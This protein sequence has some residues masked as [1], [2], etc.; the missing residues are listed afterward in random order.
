MKNID[1]VSILRRF[2]AILLRRFELLLIPML[3]LAP[4]GYIAYKTMP[5]KY[6]SFTKILI[7]EP[8]SSQNI[9]ER[10]TSSEHASERI[11]LL[12]NI[13]M[14]QKILG[15]LADYIATQESVKLTPRQRHEKILGLRSQVSIWRVAPQIVQIEY[16][17]KKPQACLDHLNFLYD[18][19]HQETLRPQREAVL[20]SSKFL[21]KQLERLNTR[22]QKSEQALTQFKRK[23]S[24]E[25]PQTFQANLNNFNALRKTIFDDQLELAAAIRRQEFLKQR[26]ERLDPTLLQ[27]RSQ[28]IQLFELQIQLRNL[29]AKYT[30]KHPSVRN[31]AQ[32]LTNLK[33]SI[34]AHKIGP[35]QS[36]KQL[37]QA[38]Q[39]E[40][41]KASDRS[42]VATAVNDKYSLF[43]QYQEITLRID[44][45]QKQLSENQQQ[46]EKMKQLIAD[47]PLREQQLSEL[48]RDAELARTIY[49]QLRTL[50]EQSLLQRELN[51]FD[52]SR[53]VQVIEPAVLPLYPIA[54]KF[55]VVVGAAIFAAFALSG[56]LIAIA[57]LFDP[58]LLREEEVNEIL[59]VEVI[60]EIGTLPAIEL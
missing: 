5:R 6:K 10:I 39:W 11:N 21:S 32:R 58:T 12:I 9:L 27:L 2:Q 51:I 30:E 24:L 54:P 49:A 57:E 50:H 34:L 18:L 25:L 14:S 53:R 20:N 40:R 17:C 38:M 45:L 4:G 7:E 31:V 47:Y 1:L 43:E 33:K 35:A 44:G 42:K 37:E 36:L 52:D 59:G 48:Q 28:I 19:F 8:R 60:G 3:I 55:S 26:I 41:A 29:S 16:L 46:I 13:V 56:L 15:K 22:L 23:H